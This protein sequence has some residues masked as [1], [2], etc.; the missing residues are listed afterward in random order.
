MPPGRFGN[1]SRVLAG[2]KALFDF[3]INER[4]LC[5]DIDAAMPPPAHSGQHPA[6]DCGIN[7]GA[8]K[9][10]GGIV[11]RIDGRVGHNQVLARRLMRGLSVETGAACPLAMACARTAAFSRSTPLSSNAA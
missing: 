3:L 2:G 8:L 1:L 4:V 5:S 9:L 7:P 6:H 11:Q 10:Q